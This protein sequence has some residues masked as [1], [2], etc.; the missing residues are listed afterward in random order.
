MPWDWQLTPTLPTVPRPLPIC[1]MSDILSNHFRSLMEP[2]TVLSNLSES[3]QL[4]SLRRQVVR[5]LNWNQGAPSEDDD[6]VVA[7]GWAEPGAAG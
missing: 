2:S 4:N 7:P 1:T 3:A 5:K 6:D